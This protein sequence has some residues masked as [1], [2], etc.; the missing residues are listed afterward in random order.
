M[1]KPILR[2]ATAIAVLVITTALAQQQVAPPPV[3]LEPVVPVPPPAPDPKLLKEY[4]SIL[5]QKFT[6]DP[7]ELLRHLERVGTSDPATLPANE[8]FLLRFVTG[9]WT[10][11]RDELVQM[12]PDLAVKIYNKMLA[13]LTENRRPVVRLDDV[14]S[15]SDVA[16]ADLTNDNIRKLGQLLGIVVP[17][18][19]TFWLADRLQKGTGKFG[20][21]DPAKRLLAARLLIAGNFRDLARNYLPP[22]DQLEQIADQA[23]RDELMAFVATQEQRE[24]TQ[25]SEVQ[26]IWDENIRELLEPSP[27]KNRGWDKAKPLAAIAKV[28]TQVPQS[29]LAPILTELVKTNP[30]AAMKLLT[31]LERKVQAERNGDVPTRTANIAA[32]AS[33]ANLVADLTSAGE[34]PWT[35]ILELMADVWAGEAE[36]TFTQKKAATNQQ[37]FVLPEDLLAQAPAGK[38]AAALASSTRD[39]IDVA[40]SRLILSGANF[41][42]AADRI[43]EIGKRSA[44]AGAALAED[45]LGVW[46]KTHNPQIPE[47]LR[48]KFNLPDDARIPVTP[49]MMEKNIDSL[50]RMMAQFRQASIAPADYSKVVDAFDLA[51]SSAETYRTSHIEKVFGPMATMDEPLFFLIISRMA[52]NLGERWRTMDVQKAGMTQRDEL[53]T[54]EL[55]RQGYATALKLIDSWLQ[56]HGDSSRALTL[57]GTLLVDWGDF[58]YFQELVSSDSKMRMAGYKEKNLQAQDYF[59]RGAS[60][61][62]KQVAK[63]APSD[64]SVDA[65]LGWFNG[66]LGIGSNGQINLSKAMNRAA[67]TRIR[68][69]L[70]ALPGKASKAH[71]GMFAKIVNDR[72]AD[73]KDPLHEDLKYR[74]LASALIITKDDPFTLGAQKQVAYLDELLSEVRLQ[75]RV[76]GPTTVGRDQDFGIFVSIVHTEAMGRAAHFGQYLTNDANASGVKPKK[77]SPLVKKM[78]AAQGPR[79]ELELNITEALSPF[80]DIESITFATS[81]VKPRPT[82]QPGWDETMLAY[83]HVR[84][85]DASV[86]KIPPVQLELKFVDLSGPITIPAESA[87]TLIKVAV[88]KASAR[89]AGNIE[90]VQS[91]DTRQLNINGALTLEIKA[92]ASGLVPDLDQLLDLKAASAIATRDI[93]PHEGLQIT[94]F[95]TWGDEVAARSERLWTISLDGDQVRA[96]DIPVTFHFPQ[97]QAKDAAVTYQTYADMNLTT[98]TE[99]VTQVGRARTPAGATAVIAA[100]VRNSYVKP[101][102]IAGAVVL[103]ALILWLML[104][105]KGPAARPLRASDVFT[106]PNEVDGFAVVALLRRLCSSPLVKLKETQRSE[107]QNDLKRIEQSCFGANAGAMSESDLR[108]IASKWLRNAT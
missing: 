99:P 89:P 103:V 59:N 22:A 58:E 35:Q 43:V 68:D 32:Q 81:D 65:Y 1:K 79:D 19:E 5:N 39:R 76:D 16:P 45:F 107:L 15:L 100:S 42:Q 105:R 27:V 52:K 53:Q 74:Y 67:L 90:I 95:N 72:L 11:V 96:S 88:D 4:Q 50:A 38:W 23:V 54:L 57:A 61:Y 101:A 3:I 108:T 69:H 93:N 17:V 73:E 78:R 94:E 98:L 63:L 40:M 12:P 106:M 29:T 48:R 56:G 70:T 36:N 60:A 86:D 92:T 18:T 87:E 44:R 77:G 21:T 64:Y 30:D 51:Y 82:A 91:L 26:R 10:K 2:F 49:I 85:K 9:D 55:V 24:S 66:L 41:D 80:F 34:Q 20:G 8:R 83:L 102:I 84:A 7:N 71:I 104:R 28:I 75:T 97:P 33:V 46:A 13:D 37:R 6:R 31:A 25:R 14:I 62:G 47:P